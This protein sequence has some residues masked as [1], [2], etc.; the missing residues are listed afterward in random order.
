MTVVNGTCGFVF[1]D[2]FGIGRDIPSGNKQTVLVIPR[3]LCTRRCIAVHLDGGIRLDNGNRH[4]GGGAGSIRGGLY[5][6]CGVD[7]FRFPSNGRGAEG[8]GIAPNI[9]AVVCA[10]RAGAP[11][12]GK[13]TALVAAFATVTAVTALVFKTSCAHRTESTV[14]K[15]GNLIAGCIDGDRNITAITAIAGESAVAALTALTAIGCANT[16]NA[17]CTGGA[18]ITS[19]AVTTL[20]AL[21]TLATITGDGVKCGNGG[22]RFGNDRRCTFSAFSA[23]TALTAVR[24]FGTVFV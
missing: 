21:P 4:C 11:R 13:P 15:T 1:G 17:G 12:T 5:A 18:F 9:G 20:T 22:D 3:C 16:Q 10:F 14:Y 2:V 7:V 24:A 23:L 8:A 6:V 19:G